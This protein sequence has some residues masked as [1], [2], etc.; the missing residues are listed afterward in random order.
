MG[1]IIT[2][3]G[4]QIPI[5]ALVRLNQSRMRNQLAQNCFAKCSH[6]FE[7]VLYSRFMCDCKIELESKCH[8]KVYSGKN[9]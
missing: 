1:D 8:S 4:S 3:V 5:Y 6:E 2:S 9:L 7:I